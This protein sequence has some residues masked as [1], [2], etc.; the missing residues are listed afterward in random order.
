MK[1]II[2][3][4]II[5]ESLFFS[6]IAT[7]VV[8]ILIGL[9]VFFNSLEEGSLS[10]KQ[11]LYVMVYSVLRLGEFSGIILSFGCIIGIV[12]AINIMGKNFEI[13]SIRNFGVPDTTLVRPFIIVAILFAII[14]LIFSN[15]LSPA[16]ISQSKIVLFTKIKKEEGFK[17]LSPIDTWVKNNDYICNIFYY[18]TI[19]NMA[20]DVTCLEIKEGKGIVSYLSMD[21]MEW[22]DGWI[23]RNVKLWDISTKEIRNIDTITDT[24]Y[25]LPK[26]KYLNKQ[27][28]DIN[29]LNIK[30]LILTLKALSISK[31]KGNKVKIEI[32]NRFLE[33]LSIP[34]LVFLIFPLVIPKPRERK[35]IGNVIIA[36]L[37]ILF[38]FLI[39]KTINFFGE[40][41]IINPILQP[42]LTVL[43][44]ISASYS[45]YKAK[46]NRI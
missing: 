36:I 35:A 33:P 30:E 9:I 11:I 3:R 7:L 38:Y 15:F 40:I 8:S 26:P 43:L 34:F 17:R 2:D 16:M 41:G 44:L 19:R 31:I 6:V 46:Y 20:F 18:D 10:L 28:K 22:K 13:V 37:I 4:Y 32:G 39:L 1:R 5:R 21:R 42:L 12:I 27:F 45:M 24:D 23:A 14:G 29:E 25:I